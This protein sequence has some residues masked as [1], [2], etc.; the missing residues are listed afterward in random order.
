MKKHGASHSRPAPFPLPL[1]VMPFTTFHPAVSMF[2]AV[3]GRIHAKHAVAA[4]ELALAVILAERC[5]ALAVDLMTPPAAMPGQATVPTAMAALPAMVAADLSFDPFHR[6]GSSQTKLAESAAPETLLDLDL[7]GVRLAAEEARRSAII[8]TPDLRQEA[9]AVG[10]EVVPG[11]TLAAV[12]QDRVTLL[13]G[14]ARESLY[15]DG[16]PR[17]E[18][19][20]MSGTAAAASPAFGAATTSA[21]RPRTS[22]ADANAGAA[23]R[24]VPAAAVRTLAAD[25]AS[26]ARPR[27]GERGMNGLA[28]VPTA[29]PGRLAPLGL[30][31]EDVVMQVDRI[32]LTS[33]QNLEGALE[34]LAE[35]RRLRLQVER[36]GRTEIVDLELEGVP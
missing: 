27:I 26:L 36:G 29:D 5:A 6:S 15:L 14:G 20:A 28:I 22:N 1:L 24:R 34:R 33:T 12:H 9:Y 4:M 23:V 18:A 21:P 3:L 31:P 8:R 16:A 2:A 30:K 17:P 7:F 13:R 10:Q 25:F 19:G 35:G 11:V 32:R